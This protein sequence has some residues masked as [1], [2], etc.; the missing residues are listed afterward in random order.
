MIGFGYPRGVGVTS[1]KKNQ[2]LVIGFG[3]PRE[4]G[5]MS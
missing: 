4:V 3:Y 2:T 5:V 1:Q